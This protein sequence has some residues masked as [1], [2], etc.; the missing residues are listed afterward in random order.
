MI[1]VQVVLHFD[2][3]ASLVVEKYNATEGKKVYSITGQRI[4]K[5]KLL[6]PNFSQAYSSIWCKEDQI[7]EAIN[8]L[9][10]FSIKKMIILKEQITK[11]FDGLQNLDKSIIHVRSYVLNQEP[12]KIDESML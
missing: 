10:D 7:E 5:D 6:L 1:L 3:D 11:K 4:P 8:V 9:Y 2:D 12:I